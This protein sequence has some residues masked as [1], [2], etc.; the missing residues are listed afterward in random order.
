MQQGW[1]NANAQLLLRT[2]ASWQMSAGQ[3]PLVAQEQDDPE[4]KWGLDLPGIHNL[5]KGSTRVYCF[6][7]LDLPGPQF[8]VFRG[9]RQSQ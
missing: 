2:A 4:L 7:C 1:G 5:Y 8:L 3:V 6:S 9:T